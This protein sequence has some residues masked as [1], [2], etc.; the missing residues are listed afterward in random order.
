MD[1][2][3][4]KSSIKVTASPDCKPIKFKATA[5]VS[6]AELIERYTVGEYQEDRE[7]EVS[8]D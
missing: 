4:I 8:S 5:G 2:I 6:N 7:E 1:K 3:D